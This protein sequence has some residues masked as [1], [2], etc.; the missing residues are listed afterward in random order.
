MHVF[1]PKHRST[2]DPLAGMASTTTEREPMRAQDP[3]VPVGGFID[4]F[5]LWPID[6]SGEVCL[7]PNTDARAEWRLR[8][9][10]IDVSG[11]EIPL[12]GIVVWRPI[13]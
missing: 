6:S 10:L 8:A 2:P 11:D 9:Q 1:D 13:R 7:L 3:K 5:E 4:H 12:A